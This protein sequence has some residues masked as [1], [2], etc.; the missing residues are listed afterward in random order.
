MSLPTIT[1]Q[2]VVNAPLETV[3]KLWTGPE[4]I[5]QWNHASDDWEA[6][7]VEN[8]LRAGGRFTCVMAAK[9]GSARF[10]FGGTYTNIVD[11]SRIEY[12]MDGNGRHVTVEFVPEPDGVRVRETFDPE[13][14][15]PTEMQR[16]GWQ[17]ILN[18]FKAYAENHAAPLV[19]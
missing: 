3:W 16:D 1:V 18:N 7:S 10:D 2:A 6:P 13:T 4:H 17:S 19:R 14:E 12:D 8:D 15:N 9:D 5:T 11:Q